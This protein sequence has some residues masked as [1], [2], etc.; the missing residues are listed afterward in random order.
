MLI[1]GHQIP[2]RIICKFENLTNTSHSEMGPVCQGCP[3]QAQRSQSNEKEK[4]QY[5]NYSIES[6]H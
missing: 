6:F 4:S 3:Y 1:D 2:K 5:I